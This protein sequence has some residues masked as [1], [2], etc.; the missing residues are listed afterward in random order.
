MN[1]VPDSMGE[2]ITGIIDVMKIC[3]VIE[4]WIGTYEQFISVL[5][6]NKSSY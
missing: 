3:K 1:K 4:V 2:S 6:K 5:C